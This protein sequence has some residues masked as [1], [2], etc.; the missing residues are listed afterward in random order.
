MFSS[1]DDISGVKPYTGSITT[2]PSKKY[3]V[4]SNPRSRETSTTT[5]AYFVW[6]I[7]LLIFCLI[8][9][10]GISAVLWNELKEFQDEFHLSLA[11]GSA[12]ESL[13]L[14]ITTFS[15]NGA[16]NDEHEQETERNR[17]LEIQ[18]T[19]EQLQ[20]KLSELERRG[21]NLN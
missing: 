15:S 2:T 4:S 20:A 16:V 9:T 7:V 11:K 1:F 8:A 10:V 14:E 12:T 21:Q 19:L 17:Y 13:K 3:K 5:T 18:V 6:I